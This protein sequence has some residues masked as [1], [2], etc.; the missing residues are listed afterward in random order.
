MR[1]ISVGDARH[2]SNKVQALRLD[3]HSL[4]W[5]VNEDLQSDVHCGAPGWGVAEHLGEKVQ[6]L[7]FRSAFT[8]VGSEVVR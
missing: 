6:A 7:R 1:C 5:E 2:L 8:L 3:V 4:W